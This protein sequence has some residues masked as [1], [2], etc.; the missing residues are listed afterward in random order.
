MQIKPYDPTRDLAY[1]N[2]EGFCE[3]QIT[4][5]LSVRRRLW[6]IRARWEAMNSPDLQT[7]APQIDGDM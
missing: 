1:L 6:P 5:I 3:A 4:A 7:E 2:E